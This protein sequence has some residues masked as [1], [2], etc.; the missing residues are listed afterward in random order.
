MTTTPMTTT[1]RQ[2]EHRQR[3]AP[4]STGSSC[5][6][7][8]ASPLPSPCRTQRLT[9]SRASTKRAFTTTAATWIWSRML[10]RAGIR[11]KWQISER[12]GV[13]ETILQPA[14]SPG[15]WSSPRSGRRPRRACRSRTSIALCCPL[16][17]LSVVQNTLALVARHL[18]PPPPPLASGRTKFWW[19][20]PPTRPSTL[21]AMPA[22]PGTT[23]PPS[24]CPP[25]RPPR[26]RPGT[27]TPASR[28]TARRSTSAPGRDCASAAG[29]TSSSSTTPGASWTTRTPPTS[30]FPPATCR[31]WT[32]RT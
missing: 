26:T 7:L 22:R 21:P 29:S 6:S 17:T 27:A 2:G 31:R 3:H 18:P 15:T 1:L 28:T 23:P 20:I 30:A 13:P 19:T 8:K 5:N 10:R 16:C 4:T 14:P 12:R 25:P 11:R 32:S 24:A 9:P